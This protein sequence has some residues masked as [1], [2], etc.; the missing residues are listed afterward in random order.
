MNRRRADPSSGSQ[1]RRAAAAWLTGICLLLALPPVRADIATCHA[2]ADRG[3]AGSRDCYRDILRSEA[4]QAQRAEAWWRL[5]DVE[6]AND[7]FRRAVGSA[8]EDASIRARWGALFLAVHQAG[9]AEA[10]FNEALAL[11]PDNLEALLGRAALLVERFAGPAGSAISQVLLL[12]AGNPRALTLMAR[13]ELEAGDLNRAREI[14]LPLAQPGGR[15]SLGERLNAMALLAAADHLARTADPAERPSPWTGKA[16][17]L[18]PRFGDAYAIPA[19]F[20]VITRRYREAVALLEQAVAV[21]ADNWRAHADLGTNLLRLNRIDEGRQ[22]LERAYGGDAF[23][24][25][26]VNMLRLLDTLAGFDTTTTGQLILRTHPEETAVL[27][28]Y[29]GELVAKAWE[30]MGERYGFEFQR[31][32]VIE[33]YQHHDDFAVRTAGLPGIGILGATFGDVVVMDGPAAKPASEWDWLSAVWHEIAHVVTLNATGNRVSRWFSE[34]VSVYEESR[35][36]PS[37]N[38][39]VPLDFLEAMNGDR[40]L[41][42]TELDN[43]FLRPQYPNQIGISYVQAGLLCSYIADTHEQGLTRIL[44]A[45]AAGADTAAAVERGLGITPEA[46]DEG[47]L[48]WLDEGYGTAARGLAD[49]QA[50]TRA[51]F[52]AIG[53]GQWAEARTAAE[54]ALAIFTD[55]VGP[56]NAHLARAR[57]LE[58]TGNPGDER[59]ALAT[60]GDY[61]GRGGRDPGALLHAV[62]MYEAMDQPRAAYPFMWFLAR[63]EPLKAS[64]H[65]KLG[66]IATLKGDHGEA[67]IEYRAALALDPHDA[68][69]AHFKVAGALNALGRREEAL[70]E[71]LLALEIAPRYPEGL[72]MLREIGR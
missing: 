58:K 5:G 29:V 20:Q 65:G 43:G 14:L 56:M 48:A 12:D 51:A 39:S 49:Y 13:L 67:L 57:A 42:V 60:L 47:F 68:A 44:A 7:A 33:L 21:Q 72:E 52:A 31:P 9:D 26:T 4:D 70:R 22:H 2:L 25:E 50:E 3:D 55:Y 53:A 62:G 30:E 18:N 38:A 54:A 45:Y 19:Y 46:L 36:G 61:L 69:A 27:A 37:P 40:L 8:P 32:V 24:T 11:D 28:P 34:G 23:N 59:E 41:P 1:R 66:D 6:R 35:H 71:L 10:L 15:A 64:H 63:L 17:A 16:L